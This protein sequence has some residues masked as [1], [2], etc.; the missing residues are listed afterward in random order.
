MSKPLPETLR[1]LEELKQKQSTEYTS[2]RDALAA[3][4]KARQERILAR[5]KQY[6]AE[7]VQKEKELIDN[8]SKAAEQGGFYV[9]AEAKVAFVLRIRG[10]NGMAPQS[11]KILQLLRLRQKHNAVFVR[12][13]KATIEML[14]RVEPYIAYGYPSPAVVRQLIQQRGFANL[15]G[16]RIPLTTN[17]VVSAA[18]GRLGIESV[19]DLAH[20]IYT[21]GPNFTAASH[22]LWPFKMNTPKGGF[23]RIRRHYVE[24]GDYGNREQLID[25]LVLRML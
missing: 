23:R 2:K 12:L 21:C 7:L 15:N 4:S 17:E 18:L 5:S 10:I 14:R 22:F 3:E 1:K 6:A 8:R 16:Q 20:E 11:R 9:P 13:N 24:G 19:E 25:D